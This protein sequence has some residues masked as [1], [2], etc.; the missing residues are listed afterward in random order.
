MSIFYSRVADTNIG[1]SGGAVAGSWRGVS[2]VGWRWPP[3][4]ARAKSY[5][6]CQ[7]T[8]HDYRLQCCSRD[9]KLIVSC[10]VAETCRQTRLGCL[11][12]GNCNA[13]RHCSHCPICCRPDRKFL[14]ADT[15]TSADVNR[16]VDKLQQ[17]TPIC[18]PTCRPTKFFIG[19]TCRPTKFL[20]SLRTAV[21]Q[22]HV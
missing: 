14:S 1:P 3:A 4:A 21:W 17:L 19:P 15:K 8:Q 10:H 12:A 16:L 2:D 11:S 5:S 18:R 9:S 7:T 6:N 20:S 13:V 22:I